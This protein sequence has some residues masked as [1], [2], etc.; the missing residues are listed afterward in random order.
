MNILHNITY[1]VKSSSENVLI[2]QSTSLTRS[3]RLTDR[4][5]ERI[6][7]KSGIPVVSVDRVETFVDQR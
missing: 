5:I 7:R 4:G 1:T 6:L 3:H 2:E